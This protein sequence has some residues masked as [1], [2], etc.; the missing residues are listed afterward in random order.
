M[1]GCNIYWR[2]I[3]LSCIKQF[4][5]L[6]TK[7]NLYNARVHAC[8]HAHTQ[9]HARTHAHARARARTHTHTHTSTHTHKHTLPTFYVKWEQMAVE[10]PYVSRHYTSW[11]LRELSIMQVDI[12][13]LE[14]HRIGWF[15]FRPDEVTNWRAVIP[16]SVTRY[17]AVPT[18]VLSVCPFLWWLTC[19]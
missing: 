8:T 1:N 10:M 9:T 15:W 4:K 16:M 13:Q 6:V 19:T 14:A 7:V 17:D 3:M 12:M 11:A 2:K 18:L 5:T